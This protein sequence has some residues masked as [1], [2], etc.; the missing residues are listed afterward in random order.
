MPDNQTNEDWLSRPKVASNP[1]HPGTGIVLS[2]A[3]A[4]KEY[5]KNIT[6]D[7][8]LQRD[9]RDAFFAFAWIPRAVMSYE[10]LQ[11]VQCRGRCSKTCKRPGCLCD[12]SIGQCK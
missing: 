11:R 12:R 3:R 5:I 10:E 9:E 7:Q 1:N 8:M 4:E 6:Y 2:R